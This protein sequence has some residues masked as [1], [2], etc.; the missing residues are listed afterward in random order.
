MSVT[1]PKPGS[2]MARS[3][4]NASEHTEP[5]QC[6]ANQCLRLKSLRGFSRDNALVGSGTSCGV[7]PAASRTPRLARHCNR[8]IHFY[9]D[10]FS[11]L[12][13]SVD[14]GTHGIDYRY[15]DI[16]RAGAL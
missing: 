8:G 6:R 10:Q 2:S 15:I 14:C 5:E 1:T 9:L 3:R 16:F 11:C 13:E 4:P 12:P 7:F